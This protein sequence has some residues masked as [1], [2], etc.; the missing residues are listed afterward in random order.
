MQLGH[1]Q[2]KVTPYIVYQFQVFK[3]EVGA[4]KSGFCNA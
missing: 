3:A 1:F 4:E 2:S